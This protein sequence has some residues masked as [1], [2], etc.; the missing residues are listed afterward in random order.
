MTK[1]VKQQQ[2]LTSASPGESAENPSGALDQYQLDD[3]IEL[4]IKTIT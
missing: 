1:T 4:L 3:R 2:Q